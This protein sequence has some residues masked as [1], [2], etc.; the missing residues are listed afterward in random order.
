MIIQESFQPITYLYFDS[1]NVTFIVSISSLS[2]T[3]RYFA[4][5]DIKGNLFIWEYSKGDINLL[6]KLCAHHSDPINN[7]D[8]APSDGDSVIISST[9]GDGFLKIIIFDLQ[10][11]TVIKQFVK[12]SLP[13]YPLCC[14][15]TRLARHNL[16]LCAAAYDDYYLRFYYFNETDDELNTELQA[17]VVTKS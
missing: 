2:C 13:L 15:I 9:A 10:E 16:I 12:Q 4:S 7:I 5:G 8:I 3:G 6:H 14:A 1:E 17:S 11:M